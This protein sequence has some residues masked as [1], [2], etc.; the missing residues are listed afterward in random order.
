VAA[1]FY[2]GGAGNLRLGEEFHHNRLSLIASIGG[3]GTPD[4]HAPLWDRRRVLDVATR[5]LYT[6]RVSVKRLLDRRFPFD[7]A[8]EA[9]AWLAEHPR[10]AVKVALEYGDR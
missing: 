4:R 2:Q 10:E 6:D 1:G 5:L 7:Q 9:Y 8:A 3:W